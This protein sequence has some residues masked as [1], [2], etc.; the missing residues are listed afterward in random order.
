[1]KFAKWVFILASIYGVIVIL[2][3]YFREEEFGRDYPPA[4]THPEF[5]YGFAGSA[6][7]W[8]VLY[9]VVGLDPL[10]YRPLMLVAI[11]AKL[12]FGIGTAI[13]LALQR[14]PGLVFALSTVDILFALLFLV[15]FFKTAP[16]VG[17]SEKRA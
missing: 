10:R 14:T 17:P 6:L 8:Q 5:F 2:P 9:F 1:M 15:A 7:A 12:C 4:I 3:M 16:A 13:L 11:F